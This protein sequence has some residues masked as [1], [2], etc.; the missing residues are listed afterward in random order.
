MTTVWI[1]TDGCYS[2]YSI[3]GAFSTEKRAELFR[4]KFG[5]DNVEEYTFDEH[6]D[7]LEKGL[8]PY[9]VVM[10]KDGSVVKCEE[11][12][13]IDKSFYHVT[14]YYGTSILRL[15]VHHWARS[16][17]HAIKIAGEIRTRLIAEDLWKEV[18]NVQNSL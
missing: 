12:E 17:E 13:P 4:A 18:N 9:K 3:K 1:V 6:V 7:M 14:S 11:L 2:D 5:Y 8:T 16:E 10:N 15:F